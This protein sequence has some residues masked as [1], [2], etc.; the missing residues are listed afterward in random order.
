MKNTSVIPGTSAGTDARG[1]RRAAAAAADRGR[2][3][4]RPPHRCRV[5]HQRDRGFVQD[6]AEHVGR[7]RDA[8]GNRCGDRLRP[9]RGG[10]LPS[11]L[12]QV[13]NVRERCEEVAK[14]NYRHRRGG[15]V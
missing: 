1:R 3:L 5:H 7:P 10:Q 9:Q 12:Q 4:R 11:P 6:V 2:R 14:T 13:N 15:E 8:D